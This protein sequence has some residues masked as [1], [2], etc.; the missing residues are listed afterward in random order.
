MAKIKQSLQSFLSF[1]N[2][3]IPDTLVLKHL[4][5]Y[6]LRTEWNLNAAKEI[7]H[8]EISGFPEIEAHHG[9]NFIWSKD[10]ES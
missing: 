5:S 2:F 4:T 8:Y 6:G 7:N 1:S 3:K 9:T 10:N